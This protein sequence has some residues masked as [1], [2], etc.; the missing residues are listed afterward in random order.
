MKKNL[1]FIA[2]L[3]FTS[4][5]FCSAQVT[6]QKSI[7]G[8]LPDWGKSVRQATDGGYIVAGTTIGS[9]YNQ[10]TYLI[11]TNINGDL[12][13][14]KTFFH[15]TQYGVDVQ[16]TKDGG[17]IVLSRGL[18]LAQTI[19]IKTDAAGDTLWT[20]SMGGASAGYSIEQTTDDGYIL[21]GS[22]WGFSTSDTLN[23]VLVKINTTGDII[24][25]KSYGGSKFDEGYSVQQT[26]DSGFIMTGYTRSTGADSADVYLVKTDARGDTLWTRAFGGTR[27][28][29]GYSVKQTKDNGYIVVG[30][31]KSFGAGGRDVYLAK[32]NS[33][34]NIIWS[35][36][37]G[38]AG[39]DYGYSIQLTTDGGYII[40]GNTYSFGANNI[41]LIKTDSLGNVGWSKAISGSDG[42]SVVQTTDGGYVVTGRVTSS[43]GDEDVLLVK[44]DSKGN[45][46][47]NEIDAP[48][49]TNTVITKMTQIS[50]KVSS[51]SLSNSIWSDTVGSVGSASTLCTTVG[52]NEIKTGNSLLISPNPSPGDFELTFP[53]II[54]QGIV[55]IYTVMGE[56]VY[57]QAVNQSSNLEIN[58]GNNAPGMYF[59][60]V[61]DGERRFTQ[62]VMILR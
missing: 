13:W 40:S 46:G 54:N 55:E 39:F 14:T 33:N 1:L 5:S 45:S 3:L 28:D 51:T 12:A 18:F 58:L 42:S 29:F 10:Q 4:S 8:A 34:G 60:K 24:W 7:G 50:T 38:G 49:I 31:T 47:C 6:F 26:S 20:K 48:T 21:A 43:S 37:Y 9:G 56:R 61:L 59:V 19:L 41:Y 62:K 36:T 57:N 25:L 52:L 23:A 35:K 32:T 27:D 15:Y 16:Q 53:R 22:V 2:I 44:I 17:Y 11:K 30:S